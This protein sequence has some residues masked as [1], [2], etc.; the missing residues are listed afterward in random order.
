MHDGPPDVA[1]VGP[2]IDAVEQALADALARAS[3]AGAWST[4]ERLAAELEAQRKLSAY[5]ELT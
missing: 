3:I 5:S 4:V 2:G 1:Q